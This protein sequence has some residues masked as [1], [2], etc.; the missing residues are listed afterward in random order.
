M[1]PAWKRPMLLVQKPLTEIVFV[2]TPSIFLSSHKKR[3]SFPSKGILYLKNE[4]FF[5]DL[6]A[7]SDSQLIESKRSARSSCISL[8]FGSDSCIYF[9]PVEDCL[10]RTSNIYQQRRTKENT[11]K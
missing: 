9:S 2:V 3:M 7:P 4:Y 5:F 6:E 1:V 11:F 8:V 10:R